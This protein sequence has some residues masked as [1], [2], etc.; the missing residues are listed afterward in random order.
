MKCKTSMS[1]ASALILL[2]V[3]TEKVLKVWYE[4]DWD[5]FTT[6]DMIVEEVKLYR[7]NPVQYT[8]TQI[9]IR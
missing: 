7:K 1:L 3:K 5:A 9:G 6:K 8:Q 2:N 4:N